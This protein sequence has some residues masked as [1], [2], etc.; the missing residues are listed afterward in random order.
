MERI[1][2]PYQTNGITQVTNMLGQPLRTAVIEID[3][4][5]IRAARHPVAPICCHNPIIPG[6]I[7]AENSFFDGDG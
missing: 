3:G 1:S 6:F 7:P 2:G 4:K 5:K